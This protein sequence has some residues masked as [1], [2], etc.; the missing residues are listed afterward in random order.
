[1]KKLEIKNLHVE[2]DGKEIIKGVSLMFTPGKAYALMGP[3]GSGKSTLAYALLG[4]PKYKITKGKIILDGKD[5][6]T[7]KTEERAKKG[8]FLSFQNPAEIPGLSI[9]NFLRHAVNNK[10]EKKY[11]VPEF[12]QLLKEKMAELKMDSSFLKRSFN[13]GFSGGEKKRMEILQLALLEPRYAF[14]DETDSGLDVD[15]IK[16]VAE[17]IGKMKKKMAIIVITHYKKF[18]EYLNPDEV[19]ILCDGEIVASGGKDLVEKIEKEGFEKII[20]KWSLKKK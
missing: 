14:L 7:E 19:S 16:I 6:T 13:E 12:H 2:V 8:I 5:I 18:L 3:N 11:S 1:M 17:A 15:A 4:H 9:S 20:R 10:H